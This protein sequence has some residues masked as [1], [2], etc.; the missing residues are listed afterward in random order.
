MQ[1]YGDF[2]SLARNI[3]KKGEK[4]GEW[5]DFVRAEI[6]KDAGRG[7]KRGGHG[8]VRGSEGRAPSPRLCERDSTE[9][10]KGARDKT[11]AQVD[12]T[13]AQARKT[14]A[15]RGKILAAAV[16]GGNGETHY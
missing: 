1:R 16:F 5:S 4:S 11:T 12:K 6:A 7:G 3:E 10:R 9:R 14:A 2:S 8:G 15:A 13:T